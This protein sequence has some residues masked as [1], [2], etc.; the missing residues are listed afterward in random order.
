[1]L[2]RQR[3]GHPATPVVAV[4][5]CFVVRHAVA[6]SRS[7]WRGDDA[8]RPLSQRGD[9]QAAEL[10]ERF[11]TQQVGRVLASPARRCVTTVAA[12]AEDAGVLVELAPF[13]A[14]G[15]EGLVA[16]RRVL[17]ATDS[18]ERPGVVVACT[19]GD[20]LIGVVD[21]LVGSGAIADHPGVIPKGGAIRLV[22]A[23]GEVVAVSVVPAP[24]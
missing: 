10:A 13:L 18:L 15:S 7:G 23:E 4:H 17:A 14:E 11:S 5:T 19:H 2:R 20:V 24:D 9:R 8:L 6:L 12:I 21:G 3:A 1:M 16:L 22:V